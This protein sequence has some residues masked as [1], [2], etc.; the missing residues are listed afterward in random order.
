MGKWILL[1]ECER[2]VCVPGLLGCSGCN[3]KSKPCASLH[4]QNMQNWMRWKDKWAWIKL[5]LFDGDDWPA[6]HRIRSHW[7][8]NDSKE[9]V[10]FFPPQI[11]CREPYNVPLIISEHSEVKINRYRPL[12]SHKS[13]SNHS[14]NDIG[15]IFSLLSKENSLFPLNNNNNNYIVSC[16][17]LRKNCHGPWGM[18]WKLKWPLIGK[19]F[20]THMV[21]QHHLHIW[22]VYVIEVDR[23]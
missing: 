10:S 8:D 21:H 11:E 15:A 14:K 18:V 17:P 3:E 5:T 20:P 16:L 19:R 4:S 7:Y 1:C 2:Q 22:I 6:S 13:A 12:K 23:T 9:Y